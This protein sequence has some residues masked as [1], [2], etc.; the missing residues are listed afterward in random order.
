MSAKPRFLLV[1]MAVV[2]VTATAVSTWSAGS[3]AKEKKSAI[4]DI[5][6]GQSADLWL[7]N[8]GL[9]MP[10][11]VYTG[12]VILFRPAEADLKS[13][14]ALLEK[15]EIGEAS[16]FLEVSVLGS[17]GKE[18]Q[19]LHGFVYVY[20]NLNSIENSLW[21]KGQLAIYRYDEGKHSW[22]E[23]VAN[24][25][26]DKGAHGRLACLA[27]QSSLYALVLLPEE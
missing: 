12:K 13:P 3:A 22:S 11:S 6:A 9:Y 2:L 4:Y 14:R 19:L 10:S 27:P 21:D 5:T 7:G 26:V 16:R 24:N 18:I 1:F 23:C 8:E 25:L 20:F 17:D 15:D